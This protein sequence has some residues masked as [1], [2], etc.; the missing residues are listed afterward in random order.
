MMEYKGYY[1]AVEYDPDAHIFHGEVLN[2]RDVITF[3]GISVE[4]I[5]M[6]FHDSVDDYLE[7]C[8]KDGVAP[9]KPY[10]GRFNL[11]L[12]PELHRDLALNARK[13]ELSINRFIEKVLTEKIAML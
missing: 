9:E 12:S 10:S 6:A 1:G 7:W 13:Q 5:E 4:E 8:H 11:R 2:T 3:Q